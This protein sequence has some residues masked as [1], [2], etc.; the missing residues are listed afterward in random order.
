VTLFGTNVGKSSDAPYFSTP[1]G[2]TER[3]DLTNTPYGPST[4]AYDAIQSATGTTGVLSST[5]SGSKS[6]YW[7][8]QEIVLKPTP[9]PISIETGACGP[10]D[11]LSGT[12]TTSITFTK[13]NSAS[14]SLLLVSYLGGCFATDVTYASS[15]MTEVAQGFY[16]RQSIWKLDNPPAGT[17]DV[18]INFY[19]SDISFGAAVSFTGTNTASSTG[20]TA[21]NHDSD[22]SGP[23][24]SV[25]IT[26]LNSGSL[27]FDSLFH[28]YAQTITPISPQIK[29]SEVQEIAE[30]GGASALPTMTAGSYSLGWTHSGT[31]AVWSETAV[32]VNAAP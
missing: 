24:L 27:I 1:G 17:H 32:E 20:A 10:A 28:D 13:T 5:I 4:A 11:F 14:T 12:H 25:S 7:V 30:T 29:L 19:G 6:R 22:S 9:P 8:A 23:T 21:T 15:S 2:T 3:Y 26:T 31:N 18:V 16:S